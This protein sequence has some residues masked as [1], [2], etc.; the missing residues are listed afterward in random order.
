MA[1]DDVFRRWS[2]IK[3]ASRRRR[4]DRTETI[5]LRPSPVGSL[6]RSYVASP[7]MA[8]WIAVAVLQSVHSPRAAGVMWLAL[9]VVLA[10]AAIGF[11]AA[12]LVH[13]TFDGETLERRTIL[14]RRYRWSRGEI[15]DVNRIR[16]RS[17]AFG[18]ILEYMVISGEG[19][20]CLVRIG[21][22]WP[23]DGG[24]RVARA[25]CRRFPYVAPWEGGRDAHEERSR[26]RGWLPLH[27]RHPWLFWPI[28]SACAIL[29]FLVALGF[30]MQ[31]LGVKN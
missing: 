8:A 4:P 16:V 21:P 19:G 3:R 11:G 15:V 31:L 9:I 13:I 28:A 5:V 23:A 2:A 22:W 10:I 6:R 7:F 30:V 29:S 12:A 24:E 26:N 18:R 17:S 1:G 25:L 27:L 14:F 20:R